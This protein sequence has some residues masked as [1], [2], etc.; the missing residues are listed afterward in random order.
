[1]DKLFEERLNIIKSKPKDV[2]DRTEMIKTQTK[3]KHKITN[4]IHQFYIDHQQ[5]IDRMIAICSILKT[6]IDEN[7]LL[8]LQKEYNDFVSLMSS[9]DFFLF[10]VSQ[11][12][13]LGA[14]AIL[15]PNW[16]PNV[17]QDWLNYWGIPEVVEGSNLSK[18]P[19]A[20]ETLLNNHEAAKTNHTLVFGLTKA[21]FEKTNRYY[22][23]L[24]H[25][26]LNCH[27]WRQE[28]DLLHLKQIALHL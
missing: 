1:M 24:Q 14:N 6:D 4:K 10:S 19:N 15:D 28:L 23:S 7:T 18:E 2:T 13:E 8:Q 12:E 9:N 27:L 20:R 17:I 25:T 16:D 21:L 5:T 11:D 22:L 26:I 3:F